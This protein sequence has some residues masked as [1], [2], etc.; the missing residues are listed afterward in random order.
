MRMNFN[1][2]DETYKKLTYL[3]SIKERSMTEI[4]TDLIENCIRE[5]DKQ[6]DYLMSAT[7]KARNWTTGDN[8]G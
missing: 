7:E 4:I 1:L 6:I 2:N 8:D 3:A 5:N